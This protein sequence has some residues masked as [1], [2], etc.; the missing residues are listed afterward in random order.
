MRMAAIRVF[1][2]TD[3][4]TTLYH[5]LSPHEFHEE[6]ARYINTMCISPKQNTYFI[7]C[8]FMEETDYYTFKKNFGKIK[9]IET[10]NHLRL[11]K[12]EKEEG[13]PEGDET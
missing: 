13:D 8:L 1:T 4:Y 5:T 12:N 7:N 9:K 10:K 11:V 6:L 2:I 3:G